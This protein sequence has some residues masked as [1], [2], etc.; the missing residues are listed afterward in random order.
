MTTPDIDMMN[1][2]PLG[3]FLQYQIAG[4]MPQRIVNLLKT[5]QIQRHQRK[6]L[7][8]AAR[9]ENGLIQPV[10]IQRAIRQQGQRIV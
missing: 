6:G 10:V 7:P 8:I 3:R 1:G 9:D 5:I 4:V 2:Q